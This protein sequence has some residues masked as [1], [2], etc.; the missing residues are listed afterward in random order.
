MDENAVYY[1]L[2]NC[3]LMR[4]D[5]DDDHYY[6]GGPKDG[7]KIYFLSVTKVLDLAAPFPEGLRM[8]MR[9][10]TY[11]EQTERLRVTGDRGS[12]LHDALEKL[13]NAEKLDLYKDYQSTYE[14]DAITS[15]MRMIRFLQP[16]K[17]ETEQVVA[18]PELRLAGTLDFQG[19]VDSWKLEALQDPYKYLEIDSDGDFQLKERWLKLP[20]NSKRQRIIIDWK[21]TA[22]NAYNHKVQVAA[23][24]TMYNKS[25]KGNVSRAFT[26]RYN[27]RNKA[28]F[29]FQESHL[30]YASFKRIYDTCIEFLGEFPEPPMMKRYPREVRLYD[31][32][33]ANVPNAKKPANRPDANVS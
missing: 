8:Y 24:K 29:D 30:S 6:Y 26:W 14:K 3:E 2:V 32:V 7:E 10:S 23:Y 31:K 33:D 21:F 9:A 19:Y 28:G 25:R 17:F 11:E 1:D 20:D 13:L 12:K 4:L 5:I 18:D 22:V 15:F 27:A 16:R